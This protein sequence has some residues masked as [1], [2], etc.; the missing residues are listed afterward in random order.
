[1]DRSSD[2]GKHTLKA[3]VSGFVLSVA[4]TL[5]AYAI[6]YAHVHSGHVVISHAVVIV[7][8]L[9]FAPVQMVVQLLFF[10]HLG[11]ENKPRWRQMTLIFAVLVVLIVVV[12]SLWI[13]RNLDYR[14]TPK[15]INQ[16]MYDQADGGL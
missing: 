8:V 2:V 13:M 5:G 1:M 7:S 14:M 6:V 11:A 9:A 3:Y 12:G 10:L 16:Y 4:L 15:Q